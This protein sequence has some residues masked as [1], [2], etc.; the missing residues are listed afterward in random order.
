MMWRSTMPVPPKMQ[1]LY[2]DK[3]RLVPMGQKKGLLS[4]F[5]LNIAED[6]MIAAEERALW[7]RYGL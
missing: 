2:G 3:L 5:G 4:R 7:A 6:V 1:E